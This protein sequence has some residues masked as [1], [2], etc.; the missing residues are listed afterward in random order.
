MNVAYTDSI[1]VCSTF[2]QNIVCFKNKCSVQ[3]FK[4][5]QHIPCQVSTDLSSL[6]HGVQES[7]SCSSSQFSTASPGIHALAGQT[8]LCHSP[9]GARQWTLHH[10]QLRRTTVHA[11]IQQGGRMAR[12]KTT[13]SQAAAAHQRQRAELQRGEREEA[14]QVQREKETLGKGLVLLTSKFL[15]P[16]NAEALE[17]FGS[18]PGKETAL[19]LPAVTSKLPMESAPKAARDWELALQGH[20]F[21]AVGISRGANAPHPIELKTLRSYLILLKNLPPLGTIGQ[22]KLLSTLGD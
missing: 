6:A 10:H 16:L 5:I 14:Q 1:N 2:H 4:R 9:Q 7:L 8:S 15:P 21:K 18:T 19:Q 20:P 13:R 17:I 3:M 11:G 22:L 12:E